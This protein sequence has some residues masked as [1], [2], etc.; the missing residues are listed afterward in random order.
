MSEGEQSE[1]ILQWRKLSGDTGSK[2]CTPFF[3]STQTNESPNESSIRQLKG[4]I[5][6]S[7]QDTINKEAKLRR[8]QL[9]TTNKD[10]FARRDNKKLHIVQNK[11][12]RFSHLMSSQKVMP[13][14]EDQCPIVYNSPEKEKGRKEVAAL[15][16][17][18]FTVVDD[19]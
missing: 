14:N 9:G 7:K 18:P 10:L 8:K 6:V 4:K 13:K 15:W 5:K 2:I 19:Y 12:A 16:L 11:K 17:Q 1:P 3:S